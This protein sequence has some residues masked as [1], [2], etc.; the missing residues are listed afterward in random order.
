MQRVS[1]APVND[2][3]SASGLLAFFGGLPLSQNESEIPLRI[4]DV[5][6]PGIVNERPGGVSCVAVGAAAV[7]WGLCFSPVLSCLGDPVSNVKGIVVAVL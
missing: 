7:L 3:V 5:F 2:T 6:I 1:P 4:P